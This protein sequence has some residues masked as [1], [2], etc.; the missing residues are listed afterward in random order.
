MLHISTFFTSF[1]VLLKKLN[2]FRTVELH[3]AQLNV[4]PF[5]LTALTDLIL[6]CFSLLYQIGQNIFY[7][8][9]N[10]FLNLK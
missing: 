1:D 2:S 9:Y 6:H 5:H 3:V 4:V 10:H 7:I 8:Y